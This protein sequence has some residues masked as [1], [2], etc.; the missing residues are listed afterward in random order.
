MPQFEDT[1]PDEDAPLE[2]LR[3]VMMSCLTATDLERREAFEV[4]LEL[5]NVAKS[6]GWYENR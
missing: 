3:E 2:V 6:A 5:V 1:E 4:A